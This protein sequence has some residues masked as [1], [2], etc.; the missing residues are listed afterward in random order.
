MV[1]C[2]GCGG[3]VVYRFSNIHNGDMAYCPLCGWDEEDG[4][5]GEYG[6]DHERDIS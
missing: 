6:E 2:P 4:G 1:A 3:Q 5:N